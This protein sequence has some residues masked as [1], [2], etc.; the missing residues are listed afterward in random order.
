ME[1]LEDFP[2]LYAVAVSREKEKTFI[3]SLRFGTFCPTSRFVADLAE[4]LIVKFCNG[5]TSTFMPT[6]IVEVPQNL[7]K[8]KRVF[9]EVNVFSSNSDEKGRICR[10]SL[11]RRLAMNKLPD[12]V[13]FISIR[14]LV[15]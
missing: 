14:V 1:S 15:L 11:K 8:T 3:F 4:K 2:R 12:G 13:R 6:R 9:P 10:V 7:N 5:C